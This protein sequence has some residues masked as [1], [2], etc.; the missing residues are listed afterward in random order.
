MILSFKNRQTELFFR[1]GIV[2]KEFEAFKSV[3]SRKLDMLD[4]AVLLQDLKSPPG[5]RLEILYGD[6]EGQHSIRINDQYR[7]CFTWEKGNAYQ[8][9]IIDYH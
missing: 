9:E 8:V 7:I 3:A 5:N 6:R 4:A 1:E 2:V